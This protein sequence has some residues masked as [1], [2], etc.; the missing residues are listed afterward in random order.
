M[1]FLSHSPWHSNSAPLIW[2]ASSFLIRSSS[3]FFCFSWAAFLSLSPGFGRS[4]L[5]SSGTELLPSNTATNLDGSN[6]SR[7][8]RYCSVTFSDVSAFSLP[9]SCPGA[10]KAK[11]NATHAIGRGKSHRQLDKRI[12]HL[13]F[14]NEGGGTHAMLNNYVTGTSRTANVPQSNA[15]RHSLPASPGN[16]E[17]CTRCS[18]SAPILRAQRASPSE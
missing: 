2:P 16:R 13:R 11:P 6:A 10:G 14:G 8:T 4:Q 9:F 5:N 15:N 7:A 12:V 17:P 3:S 1:P 18:S